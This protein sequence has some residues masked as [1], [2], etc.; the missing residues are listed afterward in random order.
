MHTPSCNRLKNFT[1][2]PIH[3]GTNRKP[4]LAEYG[5]RLLL[6]GSIT[7]ISRIAWKTI[8]LGS[9]ALADK[10]ASPP[11]STLGYAKAHSFANSSFPWRASVQRRLRRPRLQ[12]LRQEGKHGRLA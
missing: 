1:L 7:S 9:I 4:F 5:P 3:D 11:I 6:P 12:M 2:A 10:S 8:A